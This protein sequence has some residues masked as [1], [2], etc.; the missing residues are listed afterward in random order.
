MYYATLDADGRLIAENAKIQLFETIDEAR[1]YLLD[2]IDNADQF[3]VIDGDF[4]DC[5]IRSY[6]APNGDEPYFE[7]FDADSLVIEPP[8]SHPG[9][10]AWWITPRHDVLVAT[11]AE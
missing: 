5:W 11:L 10:R 6:R 9:H 3:E 1:A 8:G 4:A 2:G 7:P